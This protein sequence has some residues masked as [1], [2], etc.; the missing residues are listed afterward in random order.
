[1]SL[2]SRLVESCSGR[3]TAFGWLMDVETK[4]QQRYRPEFVNFRVNGNELGLFY[5][6]DFHLLGI[7][8]IE[9]ISVST[10][11][12][13]TSFLSF[14]LIDGLVGLRLSEEEEEVIGCDYLEHLGRR[15]QVSPRIL[16]SPGQ[17]VGDVEIDTVVI[18]V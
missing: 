18:R 4:T 13:A 10:W 12:A 11:A 9:I 17:D 2:T 3:T 5:S 15:E 6:G 8:C 14:R 1:M 16:H 7:Q